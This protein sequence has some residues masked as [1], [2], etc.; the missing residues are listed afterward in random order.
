MGCSRVTLYT[1]GGEELPARAILEDLH[2][3]KK[4]LGLTIDAFNYRLRRT[5]GDVQVALDY[6]AQKP[7]GKLP[8]KFECPDGIKRT[9]PEIAAHLGIPRPTW[10]GRFRRIGMK[11]AWD[12]GAVKSKH[13]SRTPRSTPTVHKKK[14]S[15]EKAR[16]Q[17]ALDALPTVT[18]NEVKL[19]NNRQY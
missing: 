10:H 16:Q 7:P 11:E 18:A 5:K 15:T 17:A 8:K 19:Y 4:Y 1:W 13:A 14:I 12:M 3:Q 2:S 6:V 9:H